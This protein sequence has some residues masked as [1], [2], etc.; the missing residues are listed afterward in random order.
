MIISV[1]SK[2]VRKRPQK[3]FLQRKMPQKSC[4]ERG[5]VCVEKAFSFAVVR[6]GA[7]AFSGLSRELVAR[8][9]L[10][11]F[12]KR[13]TQKR[14]APFREANSALKTENAVA[15]CGKT[16]RRVRKKARRWRRL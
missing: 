12:K 1:L 16:Q 6:H 15:K 5:F 11:L 8:R 4:V 2:R 13:K 10:F 3:C 14:A 9:G 7:E